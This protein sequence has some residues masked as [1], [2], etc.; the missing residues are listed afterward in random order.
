MAGSRKDAIHGSM[1]RSVQHIYAR[2]GAFGLWAPGLT[3]TM[4]R[5]MANCSA[6]TGL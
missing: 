1:A 6:R 2:E 4:V 5:E 3:A